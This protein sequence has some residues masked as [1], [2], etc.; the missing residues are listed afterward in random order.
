MFDPQTK[1]LVVDDFA[2]MRKI[3]K[4]ALLKLGYANVEE[5]EDGKPALELLKAAQQAGRPF[6]VVLSDWKMPEMTGIELF[7]ACRKDLKLR[8][9]LFMLVTVESEQ[10]RMS[11]AL[12]AGVSDCMVKPCNAQTLKGKLDELWRKNFALKAA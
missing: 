4:N 9:P 1:F 7:E 12:Q 5:A 10:K 8:Q 2:T 6:D 3:L 11:E